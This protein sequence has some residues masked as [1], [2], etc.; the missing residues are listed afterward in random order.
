MGHLDRVIAPLRYIG[1]SNL[2]LINIK[3]SKQYCIFKR[4]FKQFMYLN[5]ENTFH[6]TDC[7]V[8]YLTRQI[9]FQ[10]YDK[11]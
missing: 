2:F 10:K 5:A 4:K 11:A 8:R 1:T 9:L 6:V 7:F 3:F